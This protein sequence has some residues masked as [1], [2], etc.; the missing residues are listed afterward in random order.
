MTRTTQTQA[1]NGGNA[2]TTTT[3]LQDLRFGI[4]IETVGL[5]HEG[6]MK[7]VKKGLENAGI[8]GATIS[9][10]GGYYRTYTCTMPDG[11]K[12]KGMSDASIRGANGAEIVS[13]ILR[14]TDMNAVQEIVRAV[15]RAGGKV[16]NSCGMHI[17]VDGAA[18]LAKPKALSNL[19]KLTHQ[20]EDL[21][22]EAIGMDPSR[23]RWA[24]PV[25]P[26]FLAALE[27]NRGRST[28]AIRTA[29]YETSDAGTYNTS[30]HYHGSRYRGVNLHSL[31][32]GCGTVEFRY[33]DATLHAGKVKG[34][35]QFCLALAAKALNARGASS[36]KRR[37]NAGNTKYAFRT[38]L[39][40]LGLIGD[41]YKTCRLH[42]MAN[43]SGDAAWSNSA[44]RAEARA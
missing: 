14:Y 43:L 18:F 31:F 20:Q 19:I 22:R 15:R 3:N 42:M 28:A 36:R 44:A 13:P 11:R 38:F 39:L 24:Q 27:R 16:N 4:E 34:Y 25:N 21:I 40:R 6:A 10:G 23:N 5:G 1:A 37:V 17:H 9:Y 29:W 33:F 7:A 30:Q 2:M 35:I 32:N 12:W 41:E 8:D 26:R